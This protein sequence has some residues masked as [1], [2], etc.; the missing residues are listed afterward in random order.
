MHLIRDLD[1]FTSRLQRRLSWFNLIIKGDYELFNQNEQNKKNLVLSKYF[2]IG[3]CIMIGLLTI[4][5]LL[6]KAN[7]DHL[8]TLILISCVAIPFAIIGFFKLI[9]MEIRKLYS[10]KYNNNLQEIRDYIAFSS[11]NQWLKK[12]KVSPEQIEFILLPYMEEKIVN[13]ERYSIKALIY[14]ASTG[15]VIALPVLLTNVVLL[16]AFNIDTE[17]SEISSF[18]NQIF[19]IILISF[20]A[21]FTIAYLFVSIYASPYAER[22]YKT[23][24]LV[25]RHHL[26]NNYHMEDIININGKCET[27]NNKIQRR[28]N[29]RES[30][31]YEDSFKY[32]LLVLERKELNLSYKEIKHLTKAAKSLGRKRII[33]ILEEIHSD[34]ISAMLEL[35]PSYLEHYKSFLGN[36]L[37]FIAIILAII[38]SLLPEGSSEIYSLDI[39][40]SLLLLL[41]G[42]TIIIFCSLL[43]DSNYKSIRK[44]LILLLNLAKKE[45]QNR[46]NT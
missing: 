36:Y 8:S 4:G 12:N 5:L 11:I 17:T 31:D 15:S 1:I 30:T 45:K 38:V 2:I 23:L 46:N 10:E 19:S 13:K 6:P 28:E 21:F 40:L 9:R 35:I 16:V 32:S 29:I 39:R 3:F 44:E 22:T 25:L 20:F 41:L 34:T 24:Q 43:S 37:S 27:D 42:I 26:V 18:L 14:L 33:I 7:W